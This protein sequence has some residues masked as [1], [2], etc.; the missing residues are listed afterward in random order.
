MPNIKKKTPDQ[1]MQTESGRAFVTF[2]FELFRTYSRMNSAGDEITKPFG[3]SSARWRVLG[4]ACQ[5]PKTVSAIARE[6]GLTRQSVQQIVDSLTR[7]GLTKLIDNDRH[8]TAKLVAPTPAGKSAIL[9]LNRKATGWMNWVGDSASL[10]DLDVT[11]RTLKKIR[12]RLEQSSEGRP[13]P[14]KD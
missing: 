11:I 10:S 1:K 12:A 3:L 8:K 7:E 14:E 9:R 13:Q 4:S 6:R 2:V 5:S